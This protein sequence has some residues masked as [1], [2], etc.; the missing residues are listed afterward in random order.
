[1]V[2]GTA[3]TEGWRCVHLS[4]S[5]ALCVCVCV[6]VC[7]ADEVCPPCYCPTAANR[8]V[9]GVPGVER[10]LEQFPTDGGQE[11]TVD[12]FKVKTCDWSRRGGRQHSVKWYGGVLS[13]Y[14]L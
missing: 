7:C 5:L 11:G 2:G 10:V 6:C 9:C 4:L 12:S 14:I 8:A 13:C 1:M 3:P